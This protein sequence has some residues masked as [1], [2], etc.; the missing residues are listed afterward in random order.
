MRRCCSTPST[1]GADRLSLTTYDWVHYVSLSA[2][3]ENCARIV[4]RKQYVA[5]QRKQTVSILRNKKTSL[6]FWG[7]LGFLKAAFNDFLV[8][9]PISHRISVTVFS[10]NESV[11][12]RRVA[13]MM[14]ALAYHVAITVPKVLVVR[15]C[16]QMASLGGSKAGVRWWV[17]GFM[18][19]MKG[20][21]ESRTHV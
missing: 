4:A 14:H 2:S 9:K 10:S 7:G 19:T 15:Q 12:L 17:K 8:K 16:R 20:A 6:A 13:Y 11:E 18:K 5:S 1:G 3:R 21:N